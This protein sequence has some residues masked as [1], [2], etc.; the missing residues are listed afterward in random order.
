MIT[1]AAPAANAHKSIASAAVTEPVSQRA[2]RRR[3]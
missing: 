3:L 2:V 1:L